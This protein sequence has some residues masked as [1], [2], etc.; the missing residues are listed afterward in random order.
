MINII[1]INNIT[2]NDGLASYPGHSQFFNINVARYF[3]GTRLG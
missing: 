2:Y 1:V 3:L